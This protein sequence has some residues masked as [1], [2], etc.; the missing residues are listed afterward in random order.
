MPS[1][2]INFELAN[3]FTMSPTV[4]NYTD[5]NLLEADVFANITEQCDTLLKPKGE[6]LNGYLGRSCPWNGY[7]D[8]AYTYIQS[9]TIIER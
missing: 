5:S 4:R 9:A 1:E 7:S 6:L 3:S 8:T 2:Y